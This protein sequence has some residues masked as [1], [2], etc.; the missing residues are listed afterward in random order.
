MEDS[1]ET[2]VSMKLFRSRKIARKAHTEFAVLETIPI[3]MFKQGLVENIDPIRLTKNPFPEDDRPRGEDDLKSIAFH[4]KQIRE[5]KEVEAI[6]IY[7]KKNR[8]ILLDGVHRIVAMNLEGKRKIH[9][10]IIKYETEDK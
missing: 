6:W 4:R 3:S 5:G 10:F 8:L 9:A 7:S 1:I 2:S